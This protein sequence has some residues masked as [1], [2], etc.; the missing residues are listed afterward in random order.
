MNTM[1]NSANQD[2]SNRQVEVQL[3]TY[4]IDLAPSAVGQLSETGEKRIESYV[5]NM[6][7]PAYEALLADQ[8]DLERLSVEIPAVKS[9]FR[10]MGEQADHL[11]KAIPATARKVATDWLQSDFGTAVSA[12]ERDG[13]Y[14]RRLIHC[15]L[16]DIIFS[17]LNRSATSKQ[18]QAFK[19]SM[20]NAVNAAAWAEAPV[21]SAGGP[22]YFLC[23]ALACLVAEAMIIMG[24]GLS[25][26]RGNLDVSAWV[27]SGLRRRICAADD[28]WL[29]Y[30][31]DEA[32]FL[33]ELDDT[34]IPAYVAHMNRHGKRQ[35]DFLRGFLDV[36]GMYRKSTMIA[37]QESAGLRRR[38][39]KTEEK[40]VE[41]CEQSS[42]L[43]K[44]LMTNE[45]AATA[46]VLPDN[47][48]AQQLHA[49]IEQNRTLNK[50]L[51]QA[52]E[53]LTE[54]VAEIK[55]LREFANVLLMPVGQEESAPHTLVDDQW[56]KRRVVIV[57]GHEK[58]HAKLRRELPNA[59]FIH[60]DQTDISPGVFKDSAGVL[61]CVN[62]CSHTLIWRVANEVRKN[63]LTAGFSNHNN[64][65][66][67]L[68]DLRNVLHPDS[69][70]LN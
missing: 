8:K 30:L 46:S 10:M 38:L 18:V 6:V 5:R 40:L 22:T 64:V 57:G 34:S 58:L 20:R 49:E 39:L 53:R 3:W 59:S 66:F 16:Q 17:T 65:N 70:T 12:I 55:R 25:N 41:K 61:F 2:D 67:V 43:Q 36:F 26:N 47:G 60:P 9:Y 13:E 48:L 35:A 56:K 62:Y 54:M 44:K 21:A 14:A 28:L 31:K 23:L 69:A 33:G 32:K 68:N 4:L 15:H 29:N 1:A 63:A 24:L 51:E 37:E 7:K 27:S 45:Q 42:V 52:A 50:K 11:K 19:Q